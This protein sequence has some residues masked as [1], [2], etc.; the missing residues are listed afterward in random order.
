MIVLLWLGLI[1]IPLVIGEGLFTVF[2]GKK[3]REHSEIS[4]GF[5]L[6]GIVCIGVAEAAHIAGM[7]L[8]LSIAVT[9][10]I[11]LLL[12]MCAA[13]AALLLWGVNLWK[14]RRLGEKV[15]KPTYEKTA[16][17]FVF[18]V[19]VLIQALFLFCREPIIVPG[20]IIPETVQS[21]LTEDGIYRVMPLTGTVSETGIPLRYKVLC[22]PTLYAVLCNV[23]GIEASLLVCHIVPVAVLAG[24]YVSYY[25]LSGVLFP[26]KD[27][28]QR[29][30]FLLVIAVL[31]WFTDR[32][33][34]AGGYGL[35][36]GG[37]LGTTIRNLILVPYTLAATLE[38]RWWKAWLCVLAE[39]CIAWTFWGLG[40]CVVILAGVGL[41]TLLEKKCPRIRRLM[42]IFCNKEDLA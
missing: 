2:Y 7:F 25:Y 32:G 42:Q 16:I 38:K 10:R 34:V 31:F 35:L 8:D 5:V 11:F 13:L 27:L 22:L 18:M 19:L 37:Y 14:C 1:F 9:G 40:V 33:V 21:F 12:V 28:K 30:L 6:G 15:P 20:D 4:E 17:P 26:G 3:R 29:F 36:H 41:L 24:A 39:A 23:F